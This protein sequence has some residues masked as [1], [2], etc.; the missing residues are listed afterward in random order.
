MWGGDAAI[1]SEISGLFAYIIPLVIVALLAIFLKKWY[2]V[3]AAI[4]VI[5]AML[6]VPIIVD[7]VAFEFVILMLIP[8]MMVL[9]VRFASAETPTPFKQSLTM[10]SLTFPAISLLAILFINE[11]Y[12][13]NEPS[14]A[15]FHPY[16][17]FLTCIAI[18][19]V[20]T[21]YPYIQEEYL[22]VS[23]KN[24]FFKIWGQVI[25]GIVAFIAA[26]VYRNDT[27]ITLVILLFFFTYYVFGI[28]SS[29]KALRKEASL[30]SSL[31]SFLIGESLAIILISLSYGTIPK[32]DQALI[33]I[34]GISFTVL[35]YLS[36]FFPGIF[37]QSESL[38]VVW[39]II[40]GINLILI[41]HITQLNVW[42]I[43]TMLIVLVVGSLI[44]N[45]PI[46]VPKIKKWRLLSIF[47]L[48]I[49]TI[50][51]SVYAFTSTYT[52]FDYEGMVIFIL[53]LLVSIPAF[54][55]WKKRKEVA[56]SE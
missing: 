14:W 36:L 34:I 33:F 3:I 15:V 2:S 35:A 6:C 42:L 39:I 12:G 7:Q 41:G 23:A 25:T 13:L 27:S 55:E 29:I 30:A 24:K 51:I 50:I 31:V 40:S 28:L 47:T 20:A 46:L 4:A 56:V 16:Q 32:I 10:L 44:I 49:N 43:F 18:L 53:F 22:N 19:G 1:L 5:P 21:C 54:F 52:A 26:I 8:V 37:N 9:I 17:L 38:Y 48:A 11:F 45:T